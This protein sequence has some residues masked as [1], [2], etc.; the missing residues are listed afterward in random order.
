MPQATLDR[1]ARRKPAGGSREAPSADELTAAWQAAAQGDDEARGRWQ[2][3]DGNGAWEWRDGAVRFTATEGDWASLRWDRLTPAARR[4]MGRFRV[5]VTVSGQARAA[6]ISLGDW[7]DLLARLDPSGAPR[8]IAFEADL[9]SGCWAL[10]VDGRM[11]ARSWWNE[12]IS[13]GVL[14]EGELYLKACGGRDVRFADLEVTALPPVPCRLSVILTCHRFAR[15]LGVALRNWCGQTLPAGSYEVLVVNPGSPD[16]THA[17]LSA[18]ERTWPH[19]RVREV[20]MSGTSRNKGEMINHAFAQSRGEWIWLTDSDCVF[21][22]DA[23]ARALDFA[24]GYEGPVLLFG[25]RRFLSSVETDALLAGCA[26]A[27]DDFDAIAAAADSRP[28]QAEPWGY[29]QIV[30][31]ETFQRHRYTGAMNH[32]AHSD[33][34]FIADC[35]NA[36]TPILAVPGLTC[37][38]LDHP[39]SWFGTREML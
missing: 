6:G 33:G 9:E 11:Q 23:A 2:A 10:H 27:L 31:R 25:E 21:P 15:R 19:V 37:L 12:G 30:R 1:S 3:D 16:A 24:A 32:F 38:H 36:G 18:A 35:R 20:R 7:R 14:D 5:E 28:V 34:Q 8:R 22:R 4:A 29:T 17:V 26:D 13:A 39:F